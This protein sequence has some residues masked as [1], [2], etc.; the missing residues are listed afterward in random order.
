[1][2]EVVTDYGPSPFRVYQS[3]FHKKARLSDL[4][5]LFDN[6][7]SNEELVTER[8]SLLKELHNFNKSHSFR[9]AQKQKVRWAIEAD[10]RFGLTLLVSACSI[11]FVSTSIRDGPVIL[12]ALISSV[13]S[14]FK[15]KAM[16]FKVVFE[17][18]FESVRW[19]F[20][21]IIKK[22]CVCIN[23]A[24]DRIQGMSFG[25][26]FDDSLMLS[27][28]FYAD[29]A[30]GW[31]VL[32]GV[33]LGNEMIICKVSPNR[34]L[35]SKGKLCLSVGGRLTLIKSVLTSLPLYHMSLYKAP[36]GV[37]R[38]LEF[39][40]R[41][42]F[43]GSVSSLSPWNCI[44]KELN[45][46]SAKGINLLALLKKI[47][48]NGG[49]HLFGRLRRREGREKEENPVGGVEKEQFHNL[50]EL[51]GYISLSF[52]YVRWAWLLGSLDFYGRRK[53]AQYGEKLIFRFS[54]L[55]RMGLL[56]FNT[57]RFSIAQKGNDFRRRSLCYVV[58]DLEIPQQV[59]FGILS[60]PRLE[61]LFDDNVS[62]LLL[63][64]PNRCK[65]C[66]GKNK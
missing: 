5:K 17:K 23:M 35:L 26:R 20:F 21:D 2:R 3:W 42:I 18:A 58:D 52:P 39:L 12:N 46:L 22:L 14:S 50:V 44:L 16:I 1:M 65:N 11:A 32:L 62:Y 19:D 28:L 34:L 30:E 38:D 57:T 66:N 29:D 24:E 49:E 31:D 56:A 54:L 51:V 15:S 53:I 60:H 59:L 36:L 40:R 33:R 7:L 25:I 48:G 37:L 27:H 45:S 4:D 9:L 10:W 64:V 55:R 6:G 13:Q 8:I 47:S 41:K 43:N 61:L 63:G